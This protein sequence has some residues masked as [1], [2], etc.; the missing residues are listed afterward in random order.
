[1]NT[2][3]LRPALRAFTFVEVM[4]VVIVIGILA[5]VVVPRFGTVTDDAKTAAL[6][7]ALGGVRA[8]IAGFRTD[9]L[10]AGKSPFPTL[11]EL[12][13]SGTVLQQAMPA[14]PYTNLAA[15][16]QVTSDQASKRA[17]LNEASYGWNYFVDNAASPPKAIFYSNS[18]DQTTL[19][20]S[21]G[22]TKKANEL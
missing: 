10:L 16:Q 11:T 5:A 2:L 4:V 3:L 15:I 19:L 20:D 18:T 6:Q 12:S 7:S 9:A 22:K 17:T 13:T 14:N 1:M 8:S 21:A